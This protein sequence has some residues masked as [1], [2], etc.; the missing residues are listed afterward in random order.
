MKERERE[1]KKERKRKREAEKEKEIACRCCP[2]TN[3]HYSV[4]AT[5]ASIAAQML[6]QSDQCNEYLMALK[7]IAG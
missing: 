6:L 1:T 5:G 2:S 3:V 4:F 7:S